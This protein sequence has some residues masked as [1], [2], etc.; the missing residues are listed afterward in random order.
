VIGF[1]RTKN[2]L[3]KYDKSRL[4]NADF[5]S[6]NG[7]AAAAVRSSSASNTKPRSA[8]ADPGLILEVVPKRKRR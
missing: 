3:G 5:N 6:R 4:M 1:Y 7:F 8:S 2:T